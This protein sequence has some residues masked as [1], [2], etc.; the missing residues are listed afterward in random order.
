MSIFIDERT[1]LY[2]VNC[3]YFLNFQIITSSSFF[4]P[5]LL[6]SLPYP[7]TQRLVL[8]LTVFFFIIIKERYNPITEQLFFFFSIP[9]YSFPSPHH[10]KKNLPSYSYSTKQEKALFF[11]FFMFL[12]ALKKRS[13][14]TLAFVFFLQRKF[15]Y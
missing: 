1:F 13:F 7:Q 9:T 2:Q 5:S 14:V 10:P 6:S 12:S 11:L 8:Q 3:P 4:S 15:I